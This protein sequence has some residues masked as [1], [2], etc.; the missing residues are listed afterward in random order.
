M[1]EKRGGFIDGG[2]EETK[3]KEKEHFKQPD[4]LLC[5]GYEENSGLSGAHRD[6]GSH[7]CSSSVT[8]GRSKCTYRIDAGEGKPAYAVD[9]GG[10]D[11]L[12]CIRGN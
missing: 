12:S 4:F 2:R 7:I 9:R 6:S 5:T 1:Q 10:H 11:H 3:A 8:G